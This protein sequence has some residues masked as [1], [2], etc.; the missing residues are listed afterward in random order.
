MFLEGITT[1]GAFDPSS[2]VD[3][4]IRALSVQP[5]ARIFHDSVSLGNTVPNGQHH[6]I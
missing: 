5:L 4:Q 6:M 1:L 3:P 2:E